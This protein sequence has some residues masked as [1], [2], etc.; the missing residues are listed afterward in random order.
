M[1]LLPP[2]HHLPPL[3]SPTCTRRDHSDTPLSDQ[4]S[5]P[6]AK[7]ASLDRSR[8][9]AATSP[10]APALQ[11]S[12]PAPA[13][14]SSPEVI[15]NAFAVPARRASTERSTGSTER[16]TERRTSSERLRSPRDTA[17]DA[18]ADARAGFFANKYAVEARSAPGQPRAAAGQ[19]ELAAYVAEVDA[20]IGRIDTVEADME[21][22][23]KVAARRH[24]EIEV[25]G[26]A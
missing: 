13:L 3:Y 26:R 10:P 12:P 17:A 7:D 1:R 8:E 4:G 14:Q 9:R 24:S 16:S 21:R 11:S 2:P 23:P 25:R 20:C 5:S 22:Q 18:A 6:A 15:A 19:D